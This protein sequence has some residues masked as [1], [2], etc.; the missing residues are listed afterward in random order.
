M[1]ALIP[2]NLLTQGL[3]NGMI[4]GMTQMTFGVAKI[5]KAIYSHQNPDINNYIQKLDIEYHINMVSVV[6]R[7]YSKG[8]VIN[9]REHLGDRSV[10]FTTIPKG[11]K[12]T[13]DPVQIS[14]EYLSEIIKMIHYDLAQ[15]SAEIEYHKTKWFNSWRTLNI[16][17]KLDILE[18]HHKILVSRYNDFINICGTFQKK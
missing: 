14:L 17:S 6:L 8:E 3:Y 4:T 16:K 13:N 5:L 10:I 11:S 2:Y 12:T 9:I 18:I 7:R 1:A 15:I